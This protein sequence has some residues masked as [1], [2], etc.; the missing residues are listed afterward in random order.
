VQNFERKKGGFGVQM[1]AHKI[2]SFNHL[3]LKLHGEFDLIYYTREVVAEEISSEEHPGA[4]EQ[5][6]K[7]ASEVQKAF[8]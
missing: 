7:Q 1:V 8:D 2:K 6:S 4:S 5:A 3:V